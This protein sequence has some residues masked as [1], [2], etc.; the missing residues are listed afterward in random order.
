M[1]SL[2]FS[3]VLH[4][5]KSYMSD[6]KNQKICIFE[7]FFLNTLFVCQQYAKVQSTVSCQSELVS[8]KMVD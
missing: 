8:R 6:K 4:I 7:A 2:L 3:S 5:T 1:A